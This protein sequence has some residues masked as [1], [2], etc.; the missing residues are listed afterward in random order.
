MSA[1]TTARVNDDAPANNTIGSAPTN[2]PATGSS[3]QTP[4]HTPSAAGPGHPGRARDH[5][6]EHALHD[7]FEHLDA[8]VVEPAPGALHEHPL[9]ALPPLRIADLVEAAVEDPRPVEHEEDREDQAGDERDASRRRRL[10]RLGGRS[11]REPLRDVVDEVLHPA[12][13]MDLAQQVGVLLELRGPTRRGFLEAVGRL[14][15]VVDEPVAHEA[16]RAEP[17]DHE[18]HHH[19]DRAAASA[20][21]TAP[22]DTRAP[23]SRRR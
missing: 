9:D 23:R 16:D 10:Q 19:Q 14:A 4:T 5:V 8:R 15:H 21:R 22:R 13:E 7:R 1:T 17:D 20:T 18:Q 3:V 2:T 12:R 6:R 11:A